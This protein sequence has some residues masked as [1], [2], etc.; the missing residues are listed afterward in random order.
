MTLK[1][2]TFDEDGEEEFLQ[3]LANSQKVTPV[4]LREMEIKAAEAL[5]TA[6]T[7]K[8]TQIAACIKIV[9]GFLAKHGVQGRDAVALQKVRANYLGTRP[10]Y[11]S[12]LSSWADLISNRM[13]YLV[14]E[15]V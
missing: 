1:E 3:N 4:G 11:I 14:S 12:N 7:P 8:R 5:F 2:S 10:E 9:G 6:D 15:A 13:L